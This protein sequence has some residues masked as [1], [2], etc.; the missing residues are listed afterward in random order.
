MTM[1]RK[2]TYVTDEHGRRVIISAQHMKPTLDDKLRA[3]VLKR[4]KKQ[5]ETTSAFGHNLKLRLT[6]KQYRALTERMKQSRV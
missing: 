3:R 5:T 6:A 1:S 2:K 4:L